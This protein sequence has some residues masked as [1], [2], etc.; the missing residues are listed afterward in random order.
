MIISLSFALFPIYLLFLFIS[1]SAIYLTG[2]SLKI[3]Y[4]KTSKG[5]E[6]QHEVNIAIVKNSLI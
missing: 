3:I 2:N 6:Q 5:K 4:N 1:M